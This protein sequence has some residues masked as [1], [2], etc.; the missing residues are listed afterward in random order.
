MSGDG[1]GVCK[2]IS[3]S[4]SVY[5]R[6]ILGETLKADDLFSAFVSLIPSLIKVIFCGKHLLSLM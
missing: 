4:I 6:T 5:S 1:V 2:R 3:E